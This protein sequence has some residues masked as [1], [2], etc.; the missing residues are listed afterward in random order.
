MGRAVSSVSQATMRTALREPAQ[1]VRFRDAEFTII[2]RTVLSAI[3]SMG[4]MLLMQSRG[5]GRCIRQ[6]V[7]TDRSW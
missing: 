2:A 4:T 3:P 7:S 1:K 5:V 6:F